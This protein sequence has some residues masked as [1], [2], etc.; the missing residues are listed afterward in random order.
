MIFISAIRDLYKSLSHKCTTVVFAA[1]LLMLSVWVWASQ[2]YFLNQANK[3]H[4]SYT[5][6]GS[7]QLDMKGYQYV[8]YADTSLDFL[9]RQVQSSTRVILQKSQVPMA[10]CNNIP[11][12]VIQLMEK[13]YSDLHGN[14]TSMKYLIALNLKNNELVEL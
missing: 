8:E 12:N 4:Q 2:M 11:G 9:L 7:D 5:I 13:R 10:L 6:E 1:L 14:K 3:A